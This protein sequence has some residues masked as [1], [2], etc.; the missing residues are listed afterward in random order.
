LKEMSKRD[1]WNDSGTLADIVLIVL[2]PLVLFIG[3][4]IPLESVLK[5]LKK[6]IL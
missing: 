5:L 4:Q 2:L 1:G 3:S 6:I